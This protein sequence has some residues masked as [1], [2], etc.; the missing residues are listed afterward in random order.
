MLKLPTK[1]VPP[2]AIK[3]VEVDLEKAMHSAIKHCLPLTEIRACQFHLAQAWYRK[4]QDLGMTQDYKNNEAH[5]QLAEIFFC[6]AYV[7]ARRSRGNFRL[8]IDG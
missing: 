8:H 1:H 6:L 2:E 4:I 5:L 7:A 3:R